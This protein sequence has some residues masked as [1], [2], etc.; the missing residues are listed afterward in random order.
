MQLKL[1]NVALA[2]GVWQLCQGATNADSPSTAVPN[3]HVT[4]LSQDTEQIAGR[5]D[6][7]LKQA[8]QADRLKPAPLTSD[9]EFLRRAYLDLNGVIPRV[10]EVRAFLR[11]ERPDKRILLVDRLLASPRY[12]T[13]MATIWR[14]RILPVGADASRGPEAMALQK[15]L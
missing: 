8:W 6:E 13:H 7:L 4:A 12:A 2:I 11:D 15:W 10:A 3:N 14:N 5:I 1:F 9:G